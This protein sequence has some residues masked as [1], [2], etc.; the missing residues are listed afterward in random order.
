[1]IDILDEI[2]FCKS[3]LGK[4][5]PTDIAKKLKARIAE[6]ELEILAFEQAHMSE[7][8]A[9]ILLESKRVFTDTVIRDLAPSKKKVAKLAN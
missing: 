5:T 3:L 1:M 6:K 4:D 9:K 8:D 2:R 7:M